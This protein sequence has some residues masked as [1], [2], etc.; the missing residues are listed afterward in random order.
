MAA[1]KT[2]AVAL[3]LAAVVLVGLPWLI[4]RWT[5]EVGWLQMPI[6]GMRWL[7]VAAVGFGI[8]LYVWSLIRLLRRGTSALPGEPPTA[9]ETSGWYG[10]VRHPLLLGVVAILLG[11]AIAAASLAVLAFALAY[12]SFLHVFV[13]LKEEPDLK[14]AFGDRYLAYAAAV[15]R[16]IP[17]P[18]R[19]RRDGPASSSGPPPV[20]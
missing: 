3:T 16:W 9:L 19:L 13:T 15:P 11:E 7:G 6:G 12:W 20:P 17:R 8:Y 14:R 1:L 18:R 10:R 5:R 4:A 2:V